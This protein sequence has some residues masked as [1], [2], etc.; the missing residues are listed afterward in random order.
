MKRL[1]RRAERAVS[2][3]K[4]IFLDVSKGPGKDERRR[5]TCAVAGGVAAPPLGDPVPSSLGRI[6][7]V[8]TDAQKVGV[9]QNRLVTLRMRSE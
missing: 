3:Q 2:P 6:I 8:Y 5:C 4:S 9:L 1:Q 7:S